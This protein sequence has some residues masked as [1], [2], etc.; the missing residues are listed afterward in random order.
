ML[1]YSHLIFINIYFIL[2]L[3]WPHSSFPQKIYLGNK[4]SLKQ[5][6]GPPPFS[7]QM[8]TSSDLEINIVIIPKYRFDNSIPPTKDIKNVKSDL[9]R[10]LCELTKESGGGPVIPSFF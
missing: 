4:H 8:E 10:H 9:R 3:S 2:K 7:E 1:G 5:P 6:P